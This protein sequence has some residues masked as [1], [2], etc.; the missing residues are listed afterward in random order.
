MRRA[1]DWRIVSICWF[2]DKARGET[3]NFVHKQECIFYNYSVNYLKDIE[4][5]EVRFSMT[6]RNAIVILMPFFCMRNNH[7]I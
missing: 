6:S 5:I 4:F 7:S 1:R 2:R 3:P